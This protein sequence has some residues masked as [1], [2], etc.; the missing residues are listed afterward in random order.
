MVDFEDIAYLKAADKYVSVFTQNG[1]E[2]LLTK[3]MTQLATE[4]PA[5]FIRVHRSFLVNRN[6]IFEIAK[7][8]KGRLVLKLK[9]KAQS[10]IITGETYTAQV[11]QQIGL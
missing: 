10:E 1:E 11:K 5:D 2:H 4:L 7:H 6:F 8:F 3:S 9:D